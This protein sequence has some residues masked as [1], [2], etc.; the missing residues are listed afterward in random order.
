MFSLIRNFA[1]LIMYSICKKNNA[2]TIQYD[3]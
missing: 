2:K 1:N 3:R